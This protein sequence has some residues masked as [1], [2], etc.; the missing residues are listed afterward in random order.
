MRHSGGTSVVT[1]TWTRIGCCDIR[2]TTNVWLP[3]LS[4]AFQSSTQLPTVACGFPGAAPGAVAVVEVVVAA[5]AVV[6]GVPAWVVV[7]AALVALSV[8]LE[9]SLS[10]LPKIS[11]AARKPTAT[12][13]TAI[14][15]ELEPLRSIGA[16]R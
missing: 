14:R 4:G 10:S 6:P 7:V 13:S 8:A 1:P 3:R 16:G 5:G 15:T 2:L 9:L 11:Q 12:A